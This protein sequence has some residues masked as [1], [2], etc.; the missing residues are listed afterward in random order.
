[1]A[2]ISLGETN[3]FTKLQV[4]KLFQTLFLL[5]INC[6]WQNIFNGSDC[7]KYNE[8][9]H[10]RPAC[11]AAQCRRGVTSKLSKHLA[12]VLSR[13]S[14]FILLCEVTLCMCVG[15]SS[16]PDALPVASSRSIYADG[17]YKLGF[18]KCCNNF[19]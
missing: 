2:N 14:T 8:I 6:C 4:S 17:T 9:K 16:Q 5:K 11:S 19:I 10:H 1:M 3:I 15:K 13:C 12:R 18:A 7:Y